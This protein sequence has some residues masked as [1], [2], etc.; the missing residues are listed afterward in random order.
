KSGYVKVYS[1][2]RSGEQLTLIIFK[3][4][5]IFPVSWAINSTKNE[6]FAETMTPSVLWRTSV[7]EFLGFISNKPKVLFELNRRIMERFLGL[8]RRIEYMVFGNAMDKVSSILLICA[9]RFGEASRG[10]VIID[11]GLTHNEI[12]NLVGMSRETVSIEMKKLEKK[13]LIVYRGRRIV[14]NNER[15]LRKESQPDFAK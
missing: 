12:A 13:G 1:V 7:E 9:E 14:I 4:G 6:Y 3:P 15:R 11:V 2:S 8:M 5:D 10:K